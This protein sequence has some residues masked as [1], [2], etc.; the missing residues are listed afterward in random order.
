VGEGPPEKVA[1]LATPTGRALGATIAGVE[2]GLWQGRPAPP[3]AIR[4]RRGFIHILGAR[5]H[6]LCDVKVKV[7][8]SRLVAITGVSGSGKSTLAFD[9]LHAEGQRRFLDCLP[10]YARQFIRPLARPDVDRV[11]G[12]PPT[13]SLE[14]KLSR[15]SSM[16]TVGTASEV[17]H[18]FRL[19]FAALGVAYC[20]KCAIPGEAADPAALAER[21]ACDF[22]EETLVVLAPL[23]RKRKGH[24]RDVIAAIAKRGLHEVRVDGKLYRID[25]VPHLDRYRLHEIE[26]V[27]AHVHDGAGRMARLRAAVGPALDLGGGALI[28]A[29]LNKPDRLYSTRRACPRCGAG[30]PVPDPRLFTW[31]QTFG[32]CQVCHGTGVDPA[33]EIN[34]GYPMPCTACGGS[35]LR[36]ESLAVRIDERSIGE[37]AALT[38][39][40]ARVW[41]TKLRGGAEEVRERIVPELKARLALLDELGVG[42]LALNRGADTLSTGEAQRIRIVAHL[43][44]NLRGVCYV[45]DEPTVGLHPRDTAALTHA[46]ARLRERGNTVVVVEH[47]E[48]VIRAADHV[49]DLGPGAGPAGGRVVAVGAPDAIVRSTKSMTG[50]WLRGEG[51]R[52]IWPRRPLGHAPRLKII[53]A[54]LHNLRNL[55]VEIPLGRLVCVTGVSGS[56]KSTLVRDVMLKALKA[57]LASDKLPS[58]LKDLRGWDRIDRAVDIDESP[59][60]RTPRSVPATYVGVMDAI[61]AIYASTPEARA[62]GYTS[63]RFSFNVAGGRCEHCQGQGRLEVKMALL[64]PVYMTC[65]A[66]GGR[67]YNLDTL[68]V[69]FKGKTIADALSMSVDEAREFFAAFPAAH[70]PLD[71]LDAIGL[72]YLTLGQ[73][74]PTLSGGEAQRIKLAAELA[75]RGSGRSLY[76][77]DEPTTGLHMADVARL[78]DVLQRLVERGDTVVVVEHNLDIACAADCIIDLG[79]E[80]GE[81]GGC[82]VGWGQ[83]EDIATVRLSRTAPF[84]RDALEYARRSSKQPAP[85]TLVHGRMRSRSTAA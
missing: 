45:L 59:I 28:V 41:V 75:V 26:A 49:I 22:P 37:I 23:V 80:G 47:E 70:G 61:R 63:S 38:V 72:G 79:P 52:P 10:T 20:P 50:L 54:R 84:L 11:E 32:A 62:R 71:F 8:R 56:G 46:L 51:E 74:S 58:V 12:V 25:E 3:S 13:V 30:L 5:E 82:V 14:Q 68:A 69:T 73:L 39:R 76:I 9:V 83:P 77:L 43:A 60:G 15:G 31:S 6:N 40:D 48:S 19:L 18:Y 29:T 7:P 33:A 36:P 55:S 85:Q 57:R 67:R 53:G 4:P 17:Y 44:S 64:P 34:H 27:I 66:C 1:E 65:E 81:A 2:V 16:S 24:H 21:I 78:L 35:R 42:Y